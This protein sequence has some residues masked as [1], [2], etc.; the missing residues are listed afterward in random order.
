MPEVISY[1]VQK[2][3]CFTAGQLSYR[4]NEW[5]KLTSDSEVLNTV[6][7]E[8]IEFTSLPLHNGA[9][10]EKQFSKSEN[11]VIAQEIQKLLSKGVI[12]KSLHEKD[13]FI[14]PIFL[15]PKPDGSHRLI[16]NLKSLNKHVLYRHFKMDSIWTAIRLMT[17]NCFMA[18]VDIKDAYYSVH[19]AQKHQKYLKFIWN[20]KLYK[21]TCFPN[22]LAFC[23]RK[24]TKLMKPV[25]ATLREKACCKTWT[26]LDL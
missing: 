17:P 14:S 9:Y 15:R 24:F 26:G 18:S 10:K 16:L 1:F 13:E 8:T 19:I 12:A 25:F 7:G 5:R 21:F 11:T 23:P 4:L 3:E 22:G 20:N 6:C 2:T